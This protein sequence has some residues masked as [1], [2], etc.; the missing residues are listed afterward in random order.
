MQSLNNGLFT[1]VKYRRALAWS[2]LTKNKRFK[3]MS[4]FQTH[5]QMS[6]LDASWQEDDRSLHKHLY[7]THSHRHLCILLCN[8]RGQSILSQGK[9]RTKKETKV[10]LTDRWGSNRFKV[11]LRSLF[12]ILSPEDSSLLHPTPPFFSRSLLLS[13]STHTIAHAHTPSL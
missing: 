7:T 2:N 6:G 3:W 10:K 4:L 8:K 5:K 11:N 12:L 9:I 1:Y 13:P